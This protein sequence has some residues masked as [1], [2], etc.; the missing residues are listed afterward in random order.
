MLISYVLSTV[1]SGFTDGI[2]ELVEPNQGTGA[3][4]DP[5]LSLEGN[6]DSTIEADLVSCRTQHAKVSSMAGQSCAAQSAGLGALAVR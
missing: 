3:C 5:L 1:Y 6:T 2:L 4:R